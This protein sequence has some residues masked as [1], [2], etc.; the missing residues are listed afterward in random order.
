M[1]SIIEEAR[2]WLGYLEHQNERLLGVY[3]A[4]IGKG[5]YTIF[6]DIVWQA[7]GQNFQRLPWCAVFVYAIYLQA[8]GWNETIQLLGYPC[9]GT[10]VLA[11]RMHKTGQWRGR[12]Y[13]PEPGDIIF[14]SSTGKHIDHCG[15][16]E[17]IDGDTVVCI[18]GNTVDPLKRFPPEQGGAVAR[19][20]RYLDDEHIFGF[21][22]IQSVF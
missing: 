15:I 1:M 17:H 10:R 21:G 18:D 2:H 8:L 19:R 5:G 13:I 14:L 11:C 7:G 20:T 6:A 9:A 4:N 12:E 16:V 3:T 22:E